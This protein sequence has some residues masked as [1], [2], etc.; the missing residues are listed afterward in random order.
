MVVGLGLCPFADAVVAENSVRFIVSRV[1]TDD[2]LIN[3][4]S[5]EIQF[6]MASHPA[7]VSTTL[8]ILPHFSVHDFL[9][10]HHVCSF[11]D[12]LIE[13]DD[14]LIDHVM[15][16]YFHPLHQWAHALHPDDPVNF[17]KRA[18]YPVIN[19]LRAPQVDHYV[20][21][22]KTQG[23]VDRNRHTLERLG[24]HRVRQLFDSF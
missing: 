15:L 19:I 13:G 10:F 12:E 21:Q 22:G 20:D 17:D 5:E 6:L 7:Q 1:A 11:I 3:A 9:R 23:I 8:L 4:V 16:A 2:A 24:A 14:T 18:P